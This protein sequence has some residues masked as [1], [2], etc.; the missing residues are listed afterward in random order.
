M[1]PIL[2]CS[3]GLEK[4]VGSVKDKEIGIAYELN[5]G[6][7]L[8]VGRKTVLGVGRVN[9]GSSTMLDAVTIGCPRM[10]LLK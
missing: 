4:G 8:A 1:S 10:V 5:E 9:C 3:D 2:P 7:G 6:I